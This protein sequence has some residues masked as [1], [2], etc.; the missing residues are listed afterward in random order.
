MKIIYGIKD[1]KC[2]GVIDEGT[3]FNYEI[4]YNVIPYFGGNISDYSI[5]ETNKEGN[6]HLEKD[7]NNNVIVIDNLSKPTITENKPTQTEIEFAEYV[8]ATEDRIALLES[9]INGGK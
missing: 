4:K 2:V 1:L 6:F 9:K 7:K 5:I 3:D 8:L